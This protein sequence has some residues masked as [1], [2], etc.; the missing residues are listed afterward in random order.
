MSSVLRG[1]RSRYQEEYPSS[2][3]SPSSCTYNAVSLRWRRWEGQILR[4]C[5][6]RVNAVWHICG[7]T[8]AIKLYV[9]HCDRHRLHLRDPM[10]HLSTTG[11]LQRGRNY[12]EDRARG[13]M[14][15]NSNHP[16]KDLDGGIATS[17]KWNLLMCEFR[18]VEVEGRLEGKSGQVQCRKESTLNNVS[19]SV[20]VKL[21]TVTHFIHIYLCKCRYG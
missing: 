12:D 2:T 6:R 14:N 9:G 16:S 5:T 3:M 18:S 11:Q 15:T 21:C 20:K 4:K 1:T 13:F 17:A 8:S 10:M 19:A 7:T